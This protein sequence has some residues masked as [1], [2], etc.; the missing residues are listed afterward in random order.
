[1]SC[2]VVLLDLSLTCRS[3]ALLW[4]TATYRRCEQRTAHRCQVAGPLS[5]APPPGLQMSF[6]Y[7]LVTIW[8]VLLMGHRT[9]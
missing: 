4:E 9:I 1:M 8:V 2:C 7:H 5:A 6:G 3:G